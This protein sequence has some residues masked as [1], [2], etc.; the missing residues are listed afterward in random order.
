[1]NRSKQAR[2]LVLAGVFAA[3][4]TTSYAEEIEITHCYSGTFVTFSQINDVPVL[5]SWAQNGIAMSAHPKKLLHNAVIHCEGVQ[6]GGGA[7]RSGHGFCKIVDDEG[8]AIIAQIPLTGLDY[9]VKLLHGT[10]KW[11]GVTG[12]L[13]ST[14]IVRSQPNKGAMPDTYQTCRREAGQFEISK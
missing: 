1:M 3:F 14:P 10:G 6:I 2:G 8:D 4:G 11:K 13:R 5:V 12:T 7:S 9:E